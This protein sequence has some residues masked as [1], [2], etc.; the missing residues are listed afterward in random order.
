[1]E[2]FCY[3]KNYL[4]KTVPEIYLLHDYIFNAVHKNVAK[5]GKKITVV[6]IKWQ[7][8]TSN[9]MINCGFDAKVSTKFLH[10]PADCPWIQLPLNDATSHLTLAS[11]TRE[12]GLK[13]H[14][15]I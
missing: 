15:S 7:K 8:Y 1:M 4:H 2:Y 3:S 9:E 12:S 14:I 10:P 6:N 5:K 11:S 13:L